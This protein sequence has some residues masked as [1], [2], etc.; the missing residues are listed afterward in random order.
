M[1]YLEI[2]NSDRAGD[3]QDGTLSGQI[4]LQQRA[5]SISFLLFQGTKP[6]EN[7][8]VRL[9][10][11]DT[12]ASAAG[13]TI[14]LNGYF[15]RNVK[16]F[17]PGQELF[18]R[19]ADSD[20][21]KCTVLTYDETTLTIVLTAAPSGSV[22]A[23][24]KIGELLFG[25]VV[26][27]V[28]DSNVEV[29]QNLEY[30]VECIDFAKIFDKKLVPDTWAEVD[31]RYIINDFCNTVVNY[32]QTMD[33]ISYADNTAIQAEWLE[34]GA[35][36][37]PTVDTSDYLEG[38]SSGVF[39]C[40]GAGTSTFTASPTASDVDELTGASTGTPTKGFLMLWAEPDDYTK[41]T[42]I[43]LRIGSDSSNYVSVTLPNPTSN[44]WQYLKE[45]L[46][47]GTVTGTPVWTACNYIAIVV[48]HTGTVNLRLNGFR[49]NANGSFTLMHVESTPTFDDFRSAQLR[50]TTLLQL[51][52]K[53]W[54]FAWYIDYERDI[55]FFDK[56]TIPAP[57]ALTDS[58]MNFTDLQIEVDQSQLGNRIIIRGGERQSLSYYQE[59][60]QG[61]NGQREWLLKS[62]F[63][64]LDVRINDGTSAHAAA[65]GTNTTNIKIAG[66]GL[67]VG[68]HIVNV[69][70]SN[71][72]REVTAVVDVDNVTVQTITGQTSGDNITFFNAATTIGIEGIDDEST[73][74][75]V[76]NS[77]EKSVRAS[78][79]TATLPVTS[80]IRFHYK[81][82]IPIQ[83]QY[84][85]GSSI[86]ALKASGFGDGIFDLD[87]ITDSNIRDVS[88][89]IALGKAKVTEFSSA[90]ITGSFSTDWNGLSA[91]QVIS[92]TESV[93]AINSSYLIQTV[94]WKQKSGQYSDYFSH[95]ISFG[96][97][98]FGVIEFYQ[99]L[100]ATKDSIELNLDDAV[101]NY[102]DSD[103]VVESSSVDL[104]T[105][106][107][108]FE[109][110][111]G[112]EDVTSDDS[113]L[114]TDFT[115]PWKF[116]TSIGQPLP[117]RFDLSSFS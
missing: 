6:T 72:I 105:V 103:E 25:G 1:I 70:R 5:D 15:E 107:G 97:S 62:K 89:A 65:V 81:E 24:D 13:A 44:T 50:P 14:T 40:T 77:N 17:Y 79:Q 113:N 73:V 51:L 22:V 41:I 7:Q 90:I 115:P 47:K 98:L 33:S 19:I 69:T 27:R 94:S 109:T 12:I 52:S 58:S 54:S 26:S 80:F 30:V 3:L 63:A 21:E 111:T 74:A 92:I 67:S 38:T 86:S 18:I 53:A 112:N 48:V 95:K 66:H 9:F 46:T 31:S 34:S 96:T 106:D 8:D 29:V 11:Y 43:T 49:L 99:K 35:G 93:R 83:V 42:S 60:K 100:L 91:G 36:G 78:S 37:N 64:E 39:P 102:V 23:G 108:G 28:T 101:D 75:Y 32:N 117:T 55:H 45:K 10:C 71:A 57:F 114:V 56:E 4:Q 110:A 61:T 16:K 84:S 104:V 87:P 88:T 59:V 68:D 85:N 2:N 20:E 82:R 116:E 76:Y